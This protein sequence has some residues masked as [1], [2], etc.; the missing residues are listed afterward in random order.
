[1]T[2]KGANM[3]GALCGVNILIK[4]LLKFCILFI[5]LLIKIVKERLKVTIM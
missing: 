4:F 5:V 1:M 3:R 2:K